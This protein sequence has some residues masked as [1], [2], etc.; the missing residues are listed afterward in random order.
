[1]F[2]HVS[3]LLQLRV[4]SQDAYMNPGLADLRTAMKG[5]W[6]AQWAG[7][8]W[9]LCCPELYKGYSWLPAAVGSFWDFASMVELPPP[10]GMD[11]HRGLKATHLCPRSLILKGYSSPRLPRLGQLRLMMPL[12][13]YPTFPGPNSVSFPVLQVSVLPTQLETFPTCHS[14]LRTCSL[15]TLTCTRTLKM[16]RPMH[17]LLSC[18]GW[19]FIQLVLNKYRL[20]FQVLL[21]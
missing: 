12:H 19:L 17:E 4:W 1:M 18:E 14:H 13:R 2:K 11:H 8:G 3:N 21:L 16:L 15:S 10:T 20:V 9:G 6:V 7:V 5:P